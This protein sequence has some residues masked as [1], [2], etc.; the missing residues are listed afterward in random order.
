MV[1]GHVIQLH[2]KYLGGGG[3][4]NIPAFLKSFHQALIMGQMRHDSQLYLGII[5]SNN[6]HPFGGYK[7]FA[8][9][10]AFL[11]PNWNVL[12][13]GVGGRQ[14]TGGGNCL[15]VRGMNS[16]GFFVDHQR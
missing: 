13:V 5:R 10:T 16:T 7:R 6:F 3:T 11:G 12:Q 4:V 8:Y 1:G 9:T 14:T 15:L 2:A